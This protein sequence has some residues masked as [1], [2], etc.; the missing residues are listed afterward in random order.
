M[1]RLETLKLTKCDLRLSEPFWILARNHYDGLKKLR[2]IDCVI[3][4][5][6]LRQLLEVI[7]KVDDFIYVDNI[8]K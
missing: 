4:D 8:D 1:K 7:D 3:T 6:V 5:D 2:V